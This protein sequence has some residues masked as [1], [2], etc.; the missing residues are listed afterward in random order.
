[1]TN[2]LSH[3]T[4]P[5]SP[6]QQTLNLLFVIQ[7]GNIGGGLSFSGTNLRKK[8][9]LAVRCENKTD[10]VGKIRKQ[11]SFSE[12]NLKGGGKHPW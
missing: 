12:K 11:S 9:I 7:T 3:G 8:A 5:H 4:A 1:V 2:N 10:S 6:L